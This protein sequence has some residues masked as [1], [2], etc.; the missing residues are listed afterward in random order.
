MKKIFTFVV[1]ASFALAASA[2]TPKSF[3]ELLQQARA[4]G[5]QATTRH[6]R[7]AIAP[8]V[9]VGETSDVQFIFPAAGNLQGSNGTFFK[10][11]VS[12]VNFNTT[13]QN[14]AVFWFAA[15]QDNTKTNPVTITI[16]ANSVVN[17][18]DFVGT[19]L[20]QTGLGTIAV[21]AVDSS[22]NLD[23]NASIDGFSRIWTPQPGSA[24]GTV[25]QSFPAVS[26]FDS[27][28]PS[29]AV[30]VGLRADTN[31]RTNVGIVNLDTV[32]HSWTI[33]SAST[34]ATTTVTVPPQSLVQTALPSGFA[35]T[36]GS[37]GLLFTPTDSSDFLWSAYG[38]SVDNTTGDGWVSRATQ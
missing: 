1:A 20:N 3:A 22:G 38:S 21:Q 28:G 11:D 4:A 33:G 35:D 6:A 16:P 12:L 17:A 36:N 2:A 9:I 27:E 26:V 24:N 37:V 34:T 15:G 14:V 30:A 10:S 13:P 25:S 29:P 5:A 18:N 19:K 8:N 31:F 23:L 32:A 7:R